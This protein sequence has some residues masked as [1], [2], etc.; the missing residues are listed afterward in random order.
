MFRN[1]S[2]YN[3][4]M[5]H[6]YTLVK[7]FQKLFIFSEKFSTDQKKAKAHSVTHLRLNIEMGLLL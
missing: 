4:T 6:C 3:V 1:G 5:L 2:C 7:S